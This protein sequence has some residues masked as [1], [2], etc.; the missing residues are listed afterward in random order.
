MHRTRPG[1]R[2][3]RPCCAR[4][5]VAIAWRRAAARVTASVISGRVRVGRGKNAF[6]GRGRL[7]VYFTRYADH[8][9]PCVSSIAW[10][11]GAQIGSS[12]LASRVGQN[13]PMPRARVKINV[14][15]FQN[16]SNARRLVL[17]RPADDMCTAYG[18]LSSDPY[19]YR[20]PSR[21]CVRSCDV[22]DR[23]DVVNETMGLLGVL[24]FHAARARQRQRR[25]FASYFIDH[26]T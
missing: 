10:L 2:P 24:S 6:D 20:Y 5:G 1:G 7:T 11:L 18:A 16:Q 19:A 23:E 17:A 14:K 9:M 13:Q 3:A 12:H 8:A 25:R 26:L 22:S 4:P 15:L 21:A